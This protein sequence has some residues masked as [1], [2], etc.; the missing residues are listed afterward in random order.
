VLCG[1]LASLAFC[2]VAGV[3]WRSQEAS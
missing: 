2:V 1:A 3:P